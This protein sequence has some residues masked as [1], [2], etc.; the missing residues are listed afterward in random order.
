M[1]DHLLGD[2]R[3]NPRACV[4]DQLSRVTRVLVRRPTGL[5]TAPVDSGP[6][7]RARSVDQL[8]W[9][10][11]AQAR[12]PVVLTKTLGPISSGASARGVDQLL[13]A[14]PALVSRPTGSTSCPVQL[15]SLS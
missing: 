5:T 4:V 9:A 2:L 14:I 15:G 12:G 7:P 8:S 1:I 3:T 13:R 6:C 11:R 10:T